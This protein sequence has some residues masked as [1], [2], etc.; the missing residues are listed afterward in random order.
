M[1]KS[2]QTPKNK[3]RRILP[4]LLTI[5]GII[6]FF[7]AFVITVEKIAV[8]KDPNHIAPCTISPLI[9]CNSV[10]KSWQAELFGFPNPLLGIA[11]F[12]IVVTVGMALFAGATFKRWFWLGLELGTVLGLVFI[13]WLFYQSVFVIEALC[14]YCMIVWAVTIPIFLY[15]TVYNIREGHLKAPQWLAKL[16]KFHLSILYLWYAL[17]IGTILIKFW[18]YWS[19]LI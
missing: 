2:E 11:G 4:W 18:Y 5:L 16:L 8:L 14:P 3:L 9:S 1:K 19:T 13:H 17:I 10:M 15:T 7:F 12:A 6:G